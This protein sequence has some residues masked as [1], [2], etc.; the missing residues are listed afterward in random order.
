[1]SDA[2]DLDLGLAVDVGVARVGRTL[3]SDA[4]DVGVEVALALALV[5]LTHAVPSTRL[6]SGHDV[7][8]CHERK[9][10]CGLFSP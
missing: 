2:F 3:L 9:K 7:Q 10:K 8:S 6:V 4:F 1:M 5:G